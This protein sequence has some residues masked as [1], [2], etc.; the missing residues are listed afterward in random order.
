MVLQPLLENAV[1]H[2][3]YKSI[4]DISITLTAICYKEQLELKVQNNFDPEGVSGGKTGIGLNNIR[5]RFR[6]LYGRED[7]LRINISENV[8]EVILNIPQD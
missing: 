7:L 2:G 4:E 6:L 5:E 3:I 1:K 8:F